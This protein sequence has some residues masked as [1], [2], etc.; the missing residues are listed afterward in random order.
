MFTAQ[1]LCDRI[2]RFFRIKSFERFGN[3]LDVL[4]MLYAIAPALTEAPPPKNSIKVLPEE[5][6]EPLTEE[7]REQR[8]AADN[9]IYQRHMRYS[10]RAMKQCYCTATL[11]KACCFDVIFICFH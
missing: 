11:H 4:L 2:C 8:A 7:E 1:S 5:A 9:V 10:N 6:P 3:V